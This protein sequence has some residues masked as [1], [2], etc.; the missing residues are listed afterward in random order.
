[1]EKL[2][3]MNLFTPPNLNT[4]SAGNMPTKPEQG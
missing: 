1:M 3:P 2:Q 4:P